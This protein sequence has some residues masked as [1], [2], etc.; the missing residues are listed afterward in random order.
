MKYR[1]SILMILSL[2]GVK[3]IAGNSFESLRDP[4]VLYFPGKL[5]EFPNI[6]LERLTP[7]FTE[8]DLRSLLRNLPA[9]SAAR[10]LGWHSQGWLIQSLESSN[11]WEGWVSAESVQTISE[12]DLQC[13]RQQIEEMKRV[14]VA[15]QEK[16]I[17]PGMTEEEVRQSLGK[18]KESSFRI[19]EKGKTMIWSYIRYE[20]VP[21]IR[22]GRDIYGRTIQVTTMIRIPRGERRVEF[23]EGKVVA[24]EE[25]KIQ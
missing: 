22:N 9:G 7:L 21:E 14:E 12:K 13:Y 1:F 24:Y 23:K 5:S 10:V 19:D 11:S 8:K 15:I 16:S 3:F 25:K 4:D 2:F 17:L 20:E 18:P 6:K